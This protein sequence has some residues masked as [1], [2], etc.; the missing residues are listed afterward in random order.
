[1][2]VSLYWLQNATEKHRS[3]IKRRVA[4]LDADK[5]GRYDSAAALEAIYCGAGSG[6]NSEFISTP[7][8]VCQLTIAKK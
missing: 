5:R 4:G 1:M 3:T 2:R 7:E 8:A 6:D